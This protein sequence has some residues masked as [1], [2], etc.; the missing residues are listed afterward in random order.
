MN[1]L[2]GEIPIVWEW[3]SEQSWIRAVELSVSGKIWEGQN[4]SISSSR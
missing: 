2:E 1:V 4:N 3:H